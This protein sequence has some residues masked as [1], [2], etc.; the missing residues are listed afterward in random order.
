MLLERVS[1]PVVLMTTGKY[2]GMKQRKKLKN[3]AFQFQVLYQPEGFLGELIQIRIHMFITTLL[4]STTKWYFIF[5]PL[6]LGEIDH[7]FS[8]GSVLI[9]KGIR[10]RKQLCKVLCCRSFVISCMFP[11]RFSQFFTSV[12]RT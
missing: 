1:K 10:S 6:T 4:N 5:L 7:R 3:M 12:N 11:T 2:F 9:L 8:Q